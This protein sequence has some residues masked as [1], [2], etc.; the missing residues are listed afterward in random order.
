MELDEEFLRALEHGM[1][2]VGGL[3]LGVDRL[4]MTLTG[5]N[6]R[7]TILFPFTRP[8]PDEFRAG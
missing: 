7:D 6:I 2:P 4:L 3:G 8:V 5:E 1:P